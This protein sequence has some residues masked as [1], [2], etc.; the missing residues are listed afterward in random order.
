MRGPVPPS[1]RIYNRAV[2]FEI[3]EAL[4]SKSIACRRRKHRR[5]RR[6][7]RD[8]RSRL[9]Q[10]LTLDVTALAASVHIDKGESRSFAGIGRLD[11]HYVLIVFSADFEFGDWTRVL[12]A[13]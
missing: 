2:P 8:L 6:P 13:L 11:G 5:D 4:L 9:K 10:Q 3:S 7:I 12:L 1:V